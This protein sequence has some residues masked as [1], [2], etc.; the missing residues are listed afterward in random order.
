MTHPFDEENYLTDNDRWFL[1]E[2]PDDV[3][4]FDPEE[5]FDIFG[6]N[7]RPWGCR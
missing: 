4:W 2:T 7:K 3:V 5:D 6:L 1:V